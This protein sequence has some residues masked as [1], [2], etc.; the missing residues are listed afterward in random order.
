MRRYEDGFTLVEVMVSLVISSV[1]LLGLAAAQL[2]SLQ[3]A[4]NSFDYTL[5]L[6]QAHNAVESTWA[7]LCD[8]QTNAVQFD[9]VKSSA[10]FERFTLTFP[11]DYNRE[12]FKVAV[13]WSDERMTDG[14][15]NRVEIEAS[16]PDLSGSC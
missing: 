8:I 4:T 6:L 14:L 1:A 16:F 3:Y 12:N 15:A 7:D 5:S 9:N 10:Q 13:A 11:N 2:K